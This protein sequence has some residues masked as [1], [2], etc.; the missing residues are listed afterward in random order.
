MKPK[1]FGESLELSTSKHEFKKIKDLFFLTLKLGLLSLVTTRNNLYCF[2]LYSKIVETLNSQI[3]VQA[4]SKSKI[5]QILF[6]DAQ[7]SLT[8]KEKNLLKKI[9]HHF[10]QRFLLQNLNRSCSALLVSQGYWNCDTHSHLE[11]NEN[12]STALKISIEKG[13][14]YNVSNLSIICPQQYKNIVSKCFGV[15]PSEKKCKKLNPLSWEI[16][17][18]RVLYHL[19]RSGY[20]NSQ[21]NVEIIEKQ[22]TT[23]S[24]VV[25]V[26][27]QLILG[28]RAIFGEVKLVGNNNILD[29][30]IQQHILFKPGDCWD[31]NLL[32]K[33][34]KNLES[35]GVFGGVQ[36]LCGENLQNNRE[37]AEPISVPVV[38]ELKEDLSNEIKFQCGLGS[39]NKTENTEFNKKMMLKSGVCFSKKSLIFPYDITGIVFDFDLTKKSIKAEYCF[40]KLKEFP[41]NLL[42][43]IFYETKKAH[44][45]KI[46][47]NNI[48]YN[49]L[50]LNLH[51]TKDFAEKSVVGL[52][53]NRQSV[54]FSKN[55]NTQALRLPNAPQKLAH[56]FHYL[57]LYPHFCF[58]KLKGNWLNESG[59]IFSIS[60]KLM[61]SLDKTNHDLGKLQMFIN[62]YLP[63]DNQTSLAAKLGV[64]FS[65]PLQSPQESQK[66]ILKHENHCWE[67]Y[68]KEIGDTFSE[69][70]PLL[71]NGISHPSN[72]SNHLGSEEI[73]DFL[74]TE[75][76]TIFYSAVEFRRLITNYAGIAVFCNT[77][78]K[79]DFQQE[80]FLGVGARSNAPLGG[81]LLDI[82]WDLKAKTL[83]WR[84]RV[85]ESF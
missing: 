24:V 35:L 43:S 54:T 3:K 44:P 84:V 52:C 82:G 13:P 59:I 2:D 81:L 8:D 51:L 53:L 12:G 48:S 26:L 58:S 31:S 63:F 72:K 83:F 71:M 41:Q 22:S 30:L 9:Y 79:R 69:L 4:T 39:C 68:R 27:I 7:Y 46:N 73:K 60:S 16:C 34:K 18:N 19:Q 78:I 10:P 45:G 74:Q 5:K 85:G 40:G 14:K 75:K 11:K 1:I 50:N 29:A 65:R 6:E 25:E 17:K 42:T 20:W 77:K 76:Q 28:E 15:H 80:T 21:C 38:I 37:K 36:L 23:N 32:Y 64:V 67:N 49:N 57:V 61:F 55:I 62:S 33:T 70:D 56:D 47:S 66:R